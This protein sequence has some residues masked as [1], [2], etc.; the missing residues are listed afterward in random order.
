MTETGWKIPLVRK[1]DMP[2]SSAEYEWKPIPELEPKKMSIPEKVKAAKSPLAL[3]DELDMFAEEA[4]EAE[5]LQRELG[6]PASICTAH[7]TR[8]KWLGLF[9]RGKI[10]PG[11]YMWRF[12]IPNGV[13]TARQL[14]EL[15]AV[16]RPYDADGDRGMWARTGCADITSRASL[17]LRG[18]RLENIPGDWR[19]L[20]AAGL[21]SIQTG[22]D[23]VRTAVG[24]PLAGI[25]PA[26]LVDTRPF[27]DAMAAHVSGGGRG[28]PDLANLPRK[29]NVC[30]VGR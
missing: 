15:A 19:R 2:G 7:E 24:S 23:S 11:T 10:A 3:L 18:V 20:A 30:Y 25:D 17:Q 9:H 16:L 27:C 22:M 1:V 8:L 26:G 14:R 29:L 28:S 5:R 13:V 21:S 4:R 12:R 6:I